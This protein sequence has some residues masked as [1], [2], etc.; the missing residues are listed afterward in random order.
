MLAQEGFSVLLFDYRGF[1]GNPGRP[2]EWGL[3][4][5]ARAARNCVASRPDVDAGRL[6]YY[7]ESLGTGVAVALAAEQPPAAMVLRSP[8]PSLTDELILPDLSRRLYDAAP[9]PKRFVL[10]PGA[11]HGDPRLQ[12]GPEVVPVHRR[13]LVESV[14]PAARA[15]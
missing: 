7:G 1:G 13:F 5:D 15:R 11:G 2:S 3:L 4:A 9:G 14:A 6:V 12:D 8:F 10:V